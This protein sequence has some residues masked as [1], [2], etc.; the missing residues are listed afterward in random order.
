[1]IEIGEPLQPFEEL[2]LQ[3]KPIEEL[4]EP[5]D[6][7]G[8]DTALSGP[9]HR[10]CK[11]VLSLILPGREH[12]VMCVMSHCSE[13]SSV[14]VGRTYFIIGSTTDS[15]HQWLTE[16]TIKSIS[17]SWSLSSISRQLLI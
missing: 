4:D 7:I 10:T 8:G 1:M 12:N 3:L 6:C 17:L 11:Y 13:V 2:L 16:M 14:T 15:H 9:E 5:L